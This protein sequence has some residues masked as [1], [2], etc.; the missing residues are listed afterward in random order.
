[1][2]TPPGP[3]P[4]V[5]TFNFI[6]VWLIFSCFLDYW[7][8]YKHFGHRRFSCFQRVSI[9]ELTANLSIFIFKKLYI[10]PTNFQF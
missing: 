1:M 8:H 4:S 9:S 7:A 3:W 6:I 5:I 10:D 2:V